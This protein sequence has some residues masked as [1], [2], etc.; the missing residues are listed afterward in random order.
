M[1]EK[2]NN[3]SETGNILL[4]VGAVLMSSGASTHR[5]RQTLERL[6]TGLGFKIELLITQRALML[7]IITKDQEQFFSRLKRTSPHRINFKIVSGISRMSWHVLD[8]EL[9]LKQI[10]T[11][12]RRLK[13]L[14]NYPL[15]VE[16]G[17]VGL[18]GAAFCHIF[19]GGLIEMLTAFI[20]TFTGLF[21]RHQSVKKKFNPYVSVY[22]ASLT[23]SLI[24]GAA[25]Y[26]NL[27]AH[28]ETAFSTAV[29]FLVPGV[30]LINSVTD[31]VDGNIQ[32]GM[33]RMTN[34]LIIAL[35]I[36]LGVL[37]VRML[38]SF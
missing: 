20:A 17:M 34:G 13:K 36:A 26:L 8:G 3:V 21:V 35:A 11:E 14:P 33:V 12:L 27:G 16:L 22:F 10:A 25:E 38:L 5:T 32:N 18:A 19:G 6:A 28:P 29:L 37:T 30:P 1:N 15:W 31:M 7:T 23:A 9:S 4:D 24:A 2:E